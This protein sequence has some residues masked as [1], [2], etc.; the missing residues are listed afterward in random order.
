MGNF[1]TSS[2]IYDN[3]CLTKEKF[4]DKFCN[5]M[6][7]EGY[8]TCEDDEAEKSYILRFTDNCKWVTITSEDYEQGNQTAHSDTGRIAQM[9]GTTCV[10]TT[11]IDSDCAVMEMYN[12]K[13][14]KADTLIMGRADDYFGENIPLPAENAWKPFLADNSS[15]KKLCD[16]VKESENYTF[17][18]EG[19]S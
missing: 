8:I 12:E 13:G 5:E 1:F 3:E 4:I 11:V 14:V 19:L 9:L 7:S 15:W 18:E 17:V 16:I 10:N 2:Q 6:K